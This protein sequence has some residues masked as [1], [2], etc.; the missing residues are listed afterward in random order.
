MWI[1][2]DIANSVVG[3][4]SDKSAADAVL[5]LNP[6]HYCKELNPDSG[7]GSTI[8][9]IFEQIRDKGTNAI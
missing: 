6:H 1:I 5:R 7:L 3:I 9:D 8:S 2:F 4:V